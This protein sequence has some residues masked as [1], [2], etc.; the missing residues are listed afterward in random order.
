MEDFKVLKSNKLNTKIKK[1]KKKKKLMGI[2]DSIPNSSWYLLNKL[3]LNISP[4]PTLCK[5]GL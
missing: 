1:K 2:T 4:K 3:A 5:Y